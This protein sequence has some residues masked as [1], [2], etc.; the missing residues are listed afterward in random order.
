[1]KKQK[2]VIKLAAIATLGIMVFSIFSINFVEASYTS[3]QPPR[4][5]D[6]KELIE[7]GDI[8]YDKDAIFS[9]ILGKFTI[10]HVGLYVG[11]FTIEGKAFSDQ[12]IEAQFKEGVNNNDVSTWDYPSR[13]NV[14]LLRVNTSQDDDDIVAGAV[15]F[16]KTQAILH[17][18]YDW[19]WWQKDSSENASSWYCSELVWAAYLNQGV[20]LEHHAP[21]E[22]IETPWVSPAEIF[23][24]EDTYVISYHSGGQSYF[25]DLDFPPGSG[26]LLPNPDYYP[27]PVFIFASPV[28]GEVIDPDGLIINKNQNQIQGAY[29]I[30]DYQTE[31]GK[32]ADL[33]VLPEKKFGTYTIKVYPESEHNGSYSL[34]VYLGGG[35]GDSQ[36]LAQNQPVPNDGE[37]DTYSIEITNPSPQ[38][39]ASLSSEGD[40]PG[41]SF[42]DTET[43]STNLSAGVLDFS[44]ETPTDDFVNLTPKE[45]NW[46]AKREVQII[47]NGTLNFFYKIK[48][49]GFASL[50]FYKFHSFT[51][52]FLSGIYPQQIDIISFWRIPTCNI[53]MIHSFPS[54]FYSL[55]MIYL[56]LVFKI[57]YIHPYMSNCKNSQK[58]TKN[59]VLIIQNIS[60][61][62]LHLNS[63]MPRL[64]WLRP[65]SNCF[66]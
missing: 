16:V 9:G 23:E 15:D 28:D 58:V 55:I 32:E 63:P 34:E 10:G 39:F 60:W 5:T 50:L 11:D 40:S 44:L 65:E 52:N 35:E 27:F 3:P 33:I 62:Y 30:E 26:D 47:N 1:M 31:T 19:R 17:K 45:E 38:T 61:F 42:Y 4:P 48:A 6:W 46:I 13:D 20:D 57:P 21:G 25:V 64:R 12:V 43:G 7:P 53:K 36:I 8:L 66:N 22:I 37:F 14:Y 51:S 54:C 41:G 24:D 29:Y 49:I 59:C 18:P 56:S 2:L